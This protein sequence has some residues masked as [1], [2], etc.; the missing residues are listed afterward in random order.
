MIRQTR[1]SC[2]PVFCLICLLVLLN[3]TWAN[4]LPAPLS[5]RYTC[6]WILIAQYSGRE[7]CIANF[8]VKGILKG[9]PVNS[10]I[11]INYDFKNYGASRRLRKRDEAALEF[12]QL[13]SVHI[14]FI[15]VIVRTMNNS[16]P[17]G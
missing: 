16:C 11:P 12:P 6:E 10:I 7:R 9:P 5:R 13:K 17:F 4:D 8:H 2:L 15:P 1:I 14:L 3:K